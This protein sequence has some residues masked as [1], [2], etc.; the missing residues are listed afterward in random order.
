[1]GL[2]KIEY[3]SEAYHTAPPSTLKILDPIHHKNLRIC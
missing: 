2:P 1:M 3:G